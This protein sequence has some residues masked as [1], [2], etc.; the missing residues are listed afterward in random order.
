MT[1]I[2]LVDPNLIFPSF[3]RNTT[4]NGIQFA[5]KNMSGLLG[6]E[7]GRLMAPRDNANRYTPLPRYVSMRKNTLP[8]LDL[9]AP[10]HDSNQR[11]C[12]YANNAVSFVRFDFFRWKISTTPAGG[13]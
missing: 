2:F 9:G 13:T 12:V 4:K 11:T 7:D 3:V 6:Q 10:Q 5:H 1:P 8:E